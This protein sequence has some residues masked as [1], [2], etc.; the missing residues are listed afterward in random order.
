MYRLAL[1]QTEGFLRSVSALLNLDL[2]IPDH[3]T[4]SRRAKR[5]DVRIGR[6]AGKEPL[7]ILI[8]STGLRVHS[9]NGSGSGPPAKG[10]D[11]RKLHIVVDSDSGDVLGSTPTTHRARDSAQV[12]GLLTQING[13]L[14]S[15]MADGA[16][17][18][19]SVYDAIAAHGSDPP[20][21]VPIPPRRD[22]KI[23]PKANAT[24]SQGDGQSRRRNHPRNRCWWPKAM[25]AGIG[26]YTAQ[27]GRD[28]D[29]SI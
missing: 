24:A 23:A 4:L 27:L 22:A 28:R 7:H 2:R 26:L 17:D 25:G 18:T 1:R 10:R 16:Y 5:L 29:L 20:A 14:I 9:G 13:Q 6:S 12:P 8:D 3:T 19:A 11:W 15:A 21:R